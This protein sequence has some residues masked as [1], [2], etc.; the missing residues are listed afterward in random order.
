MVRP[1]ADALEAMSDERLVELFDARHDLLD[2][3]PPTMAALARRAASDASVRDAL[4][5]LVRPEWQLVEALVA[6][7]HPSTPEELAHAVS[8]TP[9]QIA[10][11][12]LR[13]CTLGLVYPDESGRRLLP[14]AALR[15]IIERPAGLGPARTTDPSPDE[16][17]ARVAALPASLTQVAD[18]LAFGPALVAGDPDSPLAHALLE[19]GIAERETTP[20]G[21]RL[22]LPR[23]IHLA[24]RSGVV[25]RSFAHVPQPEAD[26]PAE[27]AA[28]PRAARA[29]AQ[30]LTADALALT[31]DRWAADPPTVLKS[32][33]VPLR[34]ARRLT[35]AAGTDLPTWATVVH[36]AWVASLVGHDGETWQVTRDF[37]EAQAA[38]A[39]ERWADLTLAWARSNYLGSLTGTA[40]HGGEA[41]RGSDEVRS[42]LSAAVGRPGAKVR[43]RHL[44]RL[45]ADTPDALVTSDFLTRSLAWAFP[46][47]PGAVVRE[48]AD[49]FLTEATVLGLLAD[50]VP[51]PL[52][53]ALATTTEAA[54]PAALAHLAATLENSLPPL[55]DHLVIGEDGS[56]T[57]EG[58]PS[59]RLGR[60]LDWA[61]ILERGAR[62][63]ARLTPDSIGRAIHAGLDAETL[64]ADLAAVSPGGVPNAAL[65]LV[66][67]EAD[68]LGQVHVGAAKAFITGGAAHIDRLLAAPEA[69]GLD[70]VRLAPT[71]VVTSADPSFVMA[72]VRA[73]Q[74][75]PLLLG[76]GGIA[77]GSTPHATLRGGPL[78]L[79]LESD[80]WQQHVDLTPAQAVARLRGAP[81]ADG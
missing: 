38:P 19:A 7:P 15:A 1:L 74:L 44:L 66:H 4:T 11:H 22:V 32:G 77:V 41:R 8:A 5:S 48:E 69:A 75:A 78:P 27:D 40:A 34:D 52:G 70:L 51:S 17:A 28:H 54:A 58:L 20:T 35:R 67:A 76:P 68:R 13:L 73:A 3:P 46:T 57:V 39:P 18:A 49:A 12:V 61:E 9:E 81:S 10:R 65:A 14:V 72:T 79:E 21:A 45:M 36:A 25:H 80:P 24:L 59:A 31:L 64:L 37:S 2:P 43:R 60:V 30:A 33:G 16:A 53:L 56:L 6:P 26:A 29:I 23:P 71:V 62:V 55:T 42:G 63:R 50:Q 47:V